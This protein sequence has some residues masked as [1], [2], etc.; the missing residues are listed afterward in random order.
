MDMTKEPAMDSR[1]KKVLSELDA[2]ADRMEKGELSEAEANIEG[3]RVFAKMQRQVDESVKAAMEERASSQRKA[4][5]KLA[6]LLLAV[7]ALLAYF[8]FL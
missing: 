5:V 7:A 8:K 3:E 1:Q 6:I 4:R 2:I